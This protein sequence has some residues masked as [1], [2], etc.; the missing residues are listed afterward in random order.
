MKA[1]APTIYDERLELFT[2][3]LS[4]IWDYLGL[5]SSENIMPA[6]HRDIAY[7]LY[8]ER[9]PK[10]SGCYSSGQWVISA[11]NLGLHTDESAN[12][13]DMREYLHHL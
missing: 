4:T 9:G 6:R 2:F 13:P 11:L 8:S 3:V 1:S 10:A 12:D 5:Q 7:S